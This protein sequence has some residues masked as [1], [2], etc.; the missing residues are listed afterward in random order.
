MRSTSCGDFVSNFSDSLARR[1]P[2]EGKGVLRRNDVS[3]AGHNRSPSTSITDTGVTSPG[4][5]KISGG[6]VAC[7]T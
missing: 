6:A 1:Q 5:V 4:H 3:A 2:T 7:P